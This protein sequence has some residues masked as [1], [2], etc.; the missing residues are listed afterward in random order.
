[1]RRRSALLLFLALAPVGATASLVG[2]AS[3]ASA[4]TV[5]LPTVVGGFGTVPKIT[6]PAVKAP[7][8]LVTKVLS[9]GHGETVEKGNLLIANY[10]GQI[11]GGKVFDSSFSRNA[12]FGVPIG[13]GAVVKGWDE[14]LVGQHVGSRVLLIVPPALGYGTAGNTGAGIKGTDTLVFVIDVVA[15]YPKSIGDHQSA[16]ILTSK[17]NGVTVANM[18]STTPKLTIGKGVKDPTA[19]SITMLARGDGAKVVPGMLVLQYVANDWTNKVV[20][21]TWKIGSPDGEYV[22]SKANPSIFDK[23]VGDRIGSRLLIELPKNSSGGGPYALEI[24][25]AAEVPAAASKP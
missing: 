2:A 24:E 25:I 13:V 11:W 21:S 1:V 3:V 8:S 17:A 18:L 10:V 16:T 14:G 7:T 12:T 5:A 20:A 4:S 19:E 23:L 6:I 22:G 9:A 15:A